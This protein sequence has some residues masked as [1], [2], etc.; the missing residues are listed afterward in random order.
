MIEPSGV[1]S[2]KRALDILALLTEERPAISIRDVVDATGLPKTTAIRLVQTLEA[3]GLLWATARG[4][5]AG[6]GLWRWSHLAR[7]TWE[8]PAEVRRLMEELAERGRETVNMYMVRDVHRVVVAQQE[9]PQQ[10]RHVVRVGDELPLWSGASSKVLLIGASPE[11]LERIAAESP[12][13]LAHLPT[14][15]RWAAEAA[16]A[17]WAVSH[18]ERETG[19]SAVAAPIRGRDGAAVGALSLS[20]PT[21][22][23]TD[24]R[25]REFAVDVVKAAGEISDRGASYLGA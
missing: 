4:Y 3:H 11:R 24:E 12:E 13:G 2:V 23:F 22:R 8:P 21:A 5:Q 17:G 16:A 9:G 6:P 15:E 7:V 19:L 10:L 25:V 14:L 18:G 20:G 1:R